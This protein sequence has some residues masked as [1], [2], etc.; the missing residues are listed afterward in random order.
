M[1]RGQS[2]SRI[3]GPT[4][5]LLTHLG[6]RQFPKILHLDCPDEG[7]RR[8]EFIVALGGAA[9]AWPGAATAQRPAMPVIG[10]LGAASASGVEYRYSQYSAKTFVYPI[11]ILNLGI[12]GFKQELYS[13][14]VTARVG[15]KF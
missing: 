7:M 13:N 14:Q 11:P 10:F 1:F 3:S 9:L 6:S 2:G 15:Y 4:L 5:S 8:R 12:V